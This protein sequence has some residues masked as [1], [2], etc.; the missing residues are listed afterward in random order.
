MRVLTDEQRQAVMQAASAVFQEVGFERAS[1]AA[2]AKR[3]GGSKQT[4]YRYFESKE[5]LFSTVMLEAAAAQADSMFALMEDK[6][7]DLGTVLEDFARAYIDF[8]L[9]PGV[10]AVTRIAVGEG[11]QGTLGPRLYQRGPA[12]GWQ[13]LAAGLERWT[14]DGRLKIDNYDVAALHLR[15][16]L[17]AGMVEPQLFGAEPVLDRD[18]AA[19][20]AI[21]AFLAIYGTAA[22]PPD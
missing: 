5:D 16:L 20:S 8:V 9:S 11:G 2:I 19:R 3:M 6:S 18:T 7:G 13:T 15:A 22:S 17:E 14:G 10:L 4:L 12:R 21:R 1:M